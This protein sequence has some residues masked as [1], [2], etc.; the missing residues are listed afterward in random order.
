MRFLPGRPLNSFL[1]RARSLAAAGL[2]LGLVSGAFA[3]P[4]ASRV[5]GDSAAIALLPP[6]S[7][8]AATLQVTG[9]WPTPCTPTFQSAILNGADLRIDARSVLS[10]CAREPTAYT[11]EVNPAAALDQAALPPAVYHVSYYAAN[12]AQAEPKLRAFALVDTRTGAA[13]SFAPET[14]FWWST[15]GAR[16]GARRN[17]F[18][19]ELQG[20][21]LTVA[22]MS[23]DRDGRG[24]WQFGTAALNGHTAHVPMLQMAG[25]SD[26]FASASANP[27]GEAGLMLDIEFR[28]NSLA[29][30]WLSRGGS[31]D[32]AALE[33]QTMDVVRLPFADAVDGS[34]WKGDWILAIDTEQT[35]L[36][37]LHFDHVSALDPSNFRLNDENAGIAVDCAIDPQNAELPPQRCVL[38]RRDGMILGEFDAIAITRMDG[39]RN[40][41]T[42]LHLLRVSR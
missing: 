30:A 20:S 13:T 39:T 18:S 17:V 37:R 24:S 27:R 3:L 19:V 15:S 10:L 28:S 6:G 34:A 12:G 31:G 42:P 40:D 7:G 35:I 25:G 23:Y 41:R 22:L 2:V 1:R 11:I 21:Q 36:Q 14:G 5:D 16:Q 38:R 29:T 33:L 8:D 32:E 4:A 26:P 9:N